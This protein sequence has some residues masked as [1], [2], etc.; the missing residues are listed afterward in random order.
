MPV[1]AAPCSVGLWG[2]DAV[3][4]TYVWAGTD[5]SGGR[6]GLCAGFAGG[7]PPDAPERRQAAHARAAEL[8]GQLEATL[9]VRS[10]SRKVSRANST[11]LG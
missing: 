1:Y 5:V 11:A 2:D 4:S 9:H 10:G 7:G 3:C 6:Q 8:L